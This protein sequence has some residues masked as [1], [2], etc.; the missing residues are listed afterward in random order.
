MPLGG[1]E[2]SVLVPA[3]RCRDRHV[4]TGTFLPLDMSA[5]AVPSPKNT[6]NFFLLKCPPD[7]ERTGRG[8]GD[9]VV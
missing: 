5:E 3:E 4:R 7:D 2:R 6:G 8:V 1:F 9:R